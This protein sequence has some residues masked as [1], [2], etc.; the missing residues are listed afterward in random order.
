MSSREMGGWMDK[1]GNPSQVVCGSEACPV[2]CP[3]RESVAGCSGEKGKGRSW[4][5]WSELQAV[6]SLPP[7][8]SLV[9]LQLTHFWCRGGKVEE[10]FKLCPGFWVLTCGAMLPK[11][12]QRASI[13]CKGPL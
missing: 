7:I 9:L 11:G 4:W 13:A 10:L 2:L 5:F 6:P 12:T 3:I 1:V 8:S